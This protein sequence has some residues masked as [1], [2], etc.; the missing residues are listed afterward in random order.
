MTAAGAPAAPVLLAVGAAVALMGLGI[1]IAA[2]GFGFMAQSFAGLSENGLIAVGIFTAMVLSLALIVPSLM[3]ATVATGSLGA[4]MVGAA[5]GLGIFALAVGGVA[6]AIA[7]VIFMIT[8]MFDSMS[9]FGES[10]RGVSPDISAL[11]SG[12]YELIGQATLAGNPLALAGFAAMTA[13]GNSRK[14]TLSISSEGMESLADSVEGVADVGSAFEGFSANISAEIDTALGSGE[15]RIEIVS[16]LE[17]LATL[18]T[19]GAG[20]TITRATTATATAGATTA[21]QKIVVEN[22]FGP[23]TIVL[24][25]G[26]ELKGFINRTRDAAERFR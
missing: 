13:F 1:G 25:D 20:D 11:T 2:A 10:I 6:L 16:T 15:K 21:S 17:H 14:T 23:L 19:A 5:P 22:K 12:L 18:S 3:G 8:R 4:V 26:T 7:G 9:K 24:E